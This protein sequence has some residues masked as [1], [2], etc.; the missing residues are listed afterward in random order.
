LDRLRIEYRSSAAKTLPTS[1]ALAAIARR[2]WLSKVS[3][4]PGSQTVMAINATAAGTA[5]SSRRTDH[6]SFFSESALER[7]MAGS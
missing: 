7:S 2:Y 6:N 4:C 5:M 1:K 3:K